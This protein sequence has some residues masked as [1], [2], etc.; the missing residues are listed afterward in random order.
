MSL[1]Q[2]YDIKLINIQ[3]ISDQKR[4]KKGKFD[5]KTF[6]LFFKIEKDS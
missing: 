1:I 5:K 2:I 6:Y 4:L 3:K